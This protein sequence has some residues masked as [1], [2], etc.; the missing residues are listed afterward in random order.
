MQGSI[1]NALLGFLLAPMLLMQPIN[2]L[3]KDNFVFEQ[4]TTADGLTSNRIHCIAQDSLGC[5][6]IGTNTGLIMIDGTNYQ[7]FIH[8]RNDLS[9]ISNNYI[10][11]IHPV[12]SKGDLLIGTRSAVNYFSRETYSFSRI[13]AVFNE[14]SDHFGSRSCPT[15]ARDADNNFWIGTSRGIMVLDQDLNRI[16]SFL[17]SSK[18]RVFRS[19]NLSKVFCDS[20]GRVIVGSRRG[21][22]ECILETGKVIRRL[23][24]LAN[25]HIQDIFEDSK[26][27]LWFGTRGWGLYMLPDGDFD[28]KLRLFDTKNGMLLN[29]RP[30]D[31]IEDIDGSYLVADRDGGLVKIDADLET[32]HFILPEV[33]SPTSINSRAI[34][35]LLLDKD[36]NLWIGTFSG[37]LNFVDRGRKKFDHHI[38]K[39]EFHVIQNN[40]IRSFHEDAQ[41]NIW[42][43][44]KEGG[45]LHKFNGQDGTFESYPYKPDE[46]GALSDGYVLCI[47]DLDDDRLIVGTFNKQFEIFNKKTGKFTNSNEL[48]NIPVSSR[49]VYNVFRRSEKEIWIATRGV[50][51]IYNPITNELKNV[52]GFMEAQLFLQKNDSM[53][54]VGTNKF[55]L[56]LFNMN[57]LEHSRVNAGQFVHSLAYDSF[58]KL[59][60]GTG[61]RGLVVIHPNLQKVDTIS[62]KQGLPHNSVKGV[63]IDGH[64]K[65]WAATEFGLAKYDQNKKTFSIYRSED[66]LQGNSFNTYAALKSTDGRMWFGGNNGFNVFNPDS[67]KESKK[68]PSVIFTSLKVFNKPVNLKNPESPL[69]KH[70]SVAEEIVLTHKQSVITIEFIAIDYSAPQNINYA[71][72]LE[73]FD[74]EWLY[75]DNKHD[76]T[77]TNLPPGNYIFRVKV[78]NLDGYWDEEGISIKIKVLP[79]W[80]KTWGFRIFISSIL[81]SLAVGSYYFRLNRL[82][83]N[84]KE[85]EKKVKDRTEEIAAK[86]QMLIDR[87][88]RLNET[89]T[90]LEERQQQIEEQSEELRL[91]AEALSESNDQLSQLNATKDKLFSIVA[92]DLKNPFSAIMGYT[93]LL[94]ERYE[95][96]EADKIKQYLGAIDV[97][98][99]KVYKL[100]ENLLQWARTQ[101]GT[102]SSNPELVS[103]T[104]VVEEINFLSAE[105]LAKKNLKIKNTVPENL[106]IF[107]D[108]NM[109]ET[110]LRNLVTN[111]IKFSGNGTIDIFSEVSE[112]KATVFVRDHGVGMDKDEVEEIFKVSSGKSSKGT[113][114][115]SGTGL[116]LL[117]S[118]EFVNHCH[119][120][121]G[122]E[123]KLGIGSTFYVTFDA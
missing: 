69:N 25:K 104:K 77:F 107:I 19:H 74:K 115:E 113:E 33:N 84:K 70:I 34:I 112:G 1:H 7:N 54:W 109:F 64:D 36:K 83:K 79:P 38:I 119:G 76:A 9:T 114:G 102:M 42:V 93:R 85:L 121:I 101:L 35:S 92:H 122:V 44:T 50:L 4:I 8:D 75:V 99:G 73:N 30:Q 23:P 108:K 32:S 45:G 66:G 6:W 13:P 3:A 37:G 87:T 120:E 65:V 12:N 24:Q 67:I 55:G 16:G 81:I 72:K 46:K 68:M 41:G 82:I 53:L 90:L 29:N 100:L 5:I 28:N 43:G 89:N 52:E 14:R 118:K 97:S 111:A 21:V 63:L 88:E 116:G 98:A 105:M 2:L 39:N 80:W 117:I 18:V 57:T 95:I 106:H 17:D 61:D 56:F 51:Q 22:D 78:S 40:K 49:A 10:L 59:W 15:I 60:I 110:V 86:N 58:G 20:K 48:T 94:V 103:V 26:G 11:D 91:Q 47:E 123:S 27:N 62:I 96:F 71:Y 31:I